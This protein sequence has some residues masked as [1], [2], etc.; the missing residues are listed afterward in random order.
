MSNSKLPH[1]HKSYWRDSVSLLSFNE[2]REDIKADIVIV[3]GGITGITTAYLLQ[4]EGFQ[5]VLIDASKL[6]K[7]TTGHTTAK[8]T[9][10]HDL[11]YDEF[12]NHLGEEKARLYY[13]ANMDGLDFIKNTID[14]LGIDCDFSMEDAYIY[15]TTDPYNQLIA[16]EH[17]AYQK[18][19]IEGELVDKIPLNIPI[20][21]AIKLKNQAQ[22]HPL[23]YLSKLVEVF[24]NN[25]GQIYEHTTAVDLEEYDESKVVTNKGFKITAKHVISASHYPFYDGGG[26]YFSRMYE[27]RSYIL[28]V[29]TSD[30][31]PGGMYLSAEDPKRSLRYTTVNGE[32]MLL[33]GG[34]SHKT[35]QGI[36]TMEHLE[37]LKV[38]AEEL[39]QNVEIPYRW[40][41]QDLI[42]LDKVPYVGHITASNANVLV[43]TGYRKWGMTN[44]TAAAK[45]LRD[46]VINR[47]NPYGELY[48]PSRFH[49][50]PQI[51]N[52]VKDNTDVAKHLIAGKFSIPPKHL[53]ELTEGEG[54]TV[55]Y[56]GRRAGAYKDEQGTLHL[57]DTTCKHLGC[58]VE[59]NEAEKSWDCPCHG[60]RYSYDGKVLDGPAKEP[61]DKLEAE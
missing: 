8:I 14:E 57:V 21:S 38:F 7:G 9:A 54:S 22:F 10:Q 61:L 52:F 24:V 3:G 41:T 23:K 19:G 4:K 17:R 32:K 48:S 36:N 25:G 50:D 28:G 49:A 51:K 58:E 16:A 11:K 37:T 39:F 29:K 40:S 13:E 43:A 2:L 53:E 15:A 35:G 6:L 26:F 12:I 5:V 20:K 27:E 33:V 31:F 56:H 47:D 46:I 60:S 59:W 55:L 45:L 1:H 44:G 18:L 42:T 34:E 30:N